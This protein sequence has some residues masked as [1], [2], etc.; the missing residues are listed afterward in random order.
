MGLRSWLNVLPLSRIRVLAKKRGR[1]KVNLTKVLRQDSFR[2]SFL[3]GLL[4]L[5]TIELLLIF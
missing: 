3:E 2:I 5:K 4:N 1:R